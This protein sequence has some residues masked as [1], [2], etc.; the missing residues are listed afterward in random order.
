MKFEDVSYVRISI[1]YYFR[2]GKISKIV[3]CERNS[4]SIDFIEVENPDEVRNRSLKKVMILEIFEKLN[5][6][7]FELIFYTE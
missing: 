6:S 7:N 3:P 2:E 1:L 5:F 4:T